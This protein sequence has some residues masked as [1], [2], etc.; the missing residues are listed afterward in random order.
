MSRA[1]EGFVLA[2]VLVVSVIVAILAAVAIPM[3]SSYVQGQKEE[4]VKNIA[5]A[6]SLAANSY[7]RRHVSGYPIHGD[8]LKIFLP[9]AG[10]YLITVNAGT[11][12]VTVTEVGSNPV[13]SST[14]PY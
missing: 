3:Y 10:K 14:L 1:R 2:E 11:R 8:S 7:T 5:Q 4:A 12:E 13:I 6:A 9:Q